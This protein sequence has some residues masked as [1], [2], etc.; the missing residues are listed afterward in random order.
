[1]GGPGGAGKNEHNAQLLSLESS[2]P[3]PRA[4]RAALLRKLRGVHPGFE[5]STTIVLQKFGLG[6][7]ADPLGYDLWRNDLLAHA[8]AA[9]D[10]QHVTP[11]RLELEGEPFEFAQ[12][13]T[14]ALWGAG[15]IDELARPEG[16]PVQSSSRSSRNGRPGSRAASRGRREEPRPGSAGAARS[17]RCM[18]SCSPPAQ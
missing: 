11:V 1:M 12:R 16:R 17:T 3:V 4:A 7:S 9:L 15:L 8:P 5:D 10:P 2:G 6:T 18:S 13:N 14:P